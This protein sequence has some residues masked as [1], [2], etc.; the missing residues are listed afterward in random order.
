MITH[1]TRKFTFA[2]AAAVL[3][4]GGIQAATIGTDGWTR[5]A[6]AG[7]AF[8]A[9]MPGVPEHKMSPIS[10]NGFTTTMHSYMV[11]S[12]RY[13]YAVFYNDLPSTPARLQ[14][15]LQNMRDACARSGRLIDE[16]EFTF[17]GYPGKSITVE[18]EGFS[19]YSRFFVANNRVYQV[20][21]GK[22][23]QDEVP[24]SANTFITSFRLTQ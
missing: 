17:N 3:L 15:T 6:P 20:M 1:T 11:D 21:F 9:I 10:A 2:T 18:K 22:R 16:K 7:G 5:V 23:V 4:A 19:L 14:D 24:E 8:S 12:G 13:I